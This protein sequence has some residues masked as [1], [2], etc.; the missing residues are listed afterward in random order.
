MNRL[1]R[2]TLMLVLAGAILTGCA[3]DETFRS[4]HNAQTD[5]RR[6][7]IV[8]ENG[9]IDKPVTTK[10]TSL[11]SD[12]SSTMGV[13]GWQNTP[14]VGTECLF[15]NQE[16]TFSPSLGMWTYSPTKYWELHSSYKFYAY[17][18]HCG[19]KPGVTASIDDV[20]HAISIN[21]I[22]LQGSNTISTGT[23][24]PPAN[25]NLVDDTDWMI[26]RTGQ[27]MD[28]MTHQEVTFNMQHI[29]SKLCVRVCRSSTFPLEQDATLIVDSLKI[30]GLIAQ[31]N[32]TQSVLPPATPNAEWVQV[33]TLPRYTVNS[34]RNVSIP[35]SAL[36][37]LESLMIPQ[38]VGTDHTVRIWYSITHTGG[39]TYRYSHLFR[40]NETFSTFETGCNYILTAVIGS[41]VE[42]ITFNGGVSV[43]DNRDYYNSIYIR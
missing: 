1:F 19:S 37:V 39:T 8:F 3:Y 20:T 2:H 13:W 34:A 17:A 43:W 9:L 22:T 11:L 33:D 29:L 24:E 32:F 36:Y 30:E 42:P 41:G 4:L 27:S 28:G 12:H 15:L 5:S 6:M 18:P 35:D 31:G 38:T 16:V 40:L 23:P 26:D 14:E 21:G 25:F 10:A 7:V